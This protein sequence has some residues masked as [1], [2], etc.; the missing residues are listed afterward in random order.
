MRE[1]TRALPD[2][3][4]RFDEPMSA[5][6]SFKIGGAARAVIFPKTRE[7]LALSLGALRRLGIE[8]LVIGCGT[9]LLVSGGELDIVAVKTVPG[10][11][12]VSAHGLS[13]SADCGVPL[14]RLASIAC[15]NGLGGLEFAHGIPGSVGGAVFMNAGAYGAEMGGVVSRVTAVSPDGEIL[16]FSRGECGFSYRNSVFNGN[17]C[18]ILSS[19]FEL[20]AGSPED[21]RRDMAARAQARRESQPLELPSA[22]SAFKRPPPDGPDG[23]TKRYAAALI[24]ECGLKGYGVGGAAVSEKHAGFIVNRSG[25]SFEDVLRVLE[26]V[27]SEVLRLRGV[28]LE[29]EIKIIGG[30][31]RWKLL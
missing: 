18:V 19:E 3:E 15:D 6:T 31:G 25:A 22:G 12:G 4:I 9:N 5:H 26:H 27:R 2:I 13:V 14:A 28:E 10:V 1:L 21:I 30:D 16:E 23:N 20:R 17:G 24:E 11:G 8:P 7:E 29:P